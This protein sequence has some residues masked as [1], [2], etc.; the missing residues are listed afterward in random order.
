MS[1]KLEIEN[2][3]RLPN[4]EIRIGQFTVF[5]GPNNTG[6]STVS[7]LL[8]SLFDAMNVNH[9]LV[10]FYDLVAPFQNRLNRLERRLGYEDANFPLSLLNE[11]IDEIE[12]IFKSFSIDN[13]EKN[14]ELWLDIIDHAN[15]LHDQYKR[16][17]PNIQR[18]FQ[19]K[20]NP[21]ISDLFT[22]EIPTD[23]F[24]KEISTDLLAKE[25]E[26]IEQALERLLKIENIDVHQFVVAG[27]EQKI[28]QNLTQ[29]FQVPTL[30]PLRTRQEKPS[31][32]S[33]DG[34]G[35]FKFEN[36]ESVYFDIEQ[37]GFQQL[38]HYSRVIY[39]ESPVYWKL[40]SAL[41]DAEISQRFVYTQKR[42]RL[43]GVPGY[44]HDLSRVLNYEYSGDIAFPK[45]YEKLISKKVLG[46]KL[47]ISKTGELSFQE[48][49]RS[50]SLHLTAM[51]V[52]NLGILAL[53]IERKIID[54]GTFLFID[55][56]EA[57]LHPSW[58]VKIA[59]TLL[60]LS[61]LGV[62]VV[63]AT[64]SAE[65]LKFLEVEVKENPENEKLIALNHFSSSGVKNYEDDFTSK[66]SNIKKE[67]TEPYT[68]LY[69]K[70]L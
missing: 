25:L 46:G 4:E 33:I 24:A 26:N 8:Y 23:L 45:L 65:I 12:N 66:L 68:D 55:E 36:S 3:G 31:R 60:E 1:F 15:K 47:T 50:F 29:N 37:V 20:R 28:F 58:Q 13:S 67:L 52:I 35:K 38:Q 5:A 40:K 18:W 19:E 27:L 17:K 54:E 6:K 70:G 10:H 34:V 48:D 59:K 42:K 57:H 64:H 2:F 44:F 22:K 61:G 62:N 41:A 49:G 43:S 56:P 11:E 32:I 63:I 53:L 69:L 21:Y 16:T 30:S 9:A 14:R 51:G 39:L 7:K